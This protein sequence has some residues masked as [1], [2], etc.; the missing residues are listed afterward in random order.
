M[1]SDRRRHRSPPF[2]N[3]VSV[4]LAACAVVFLVVLYITELRT[5]RGRVRVKVSMTHSRARKNQLILKSGYYGVPMIECNAEK[6]S[7]LFA[8]LFFTH[9]YVEYGTILYFEK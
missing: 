7:P 2:R 6:G 4:L 8:M 1:S 9:S 3:F 5:R